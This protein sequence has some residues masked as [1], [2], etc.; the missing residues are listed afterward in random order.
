MRRKR[1]DTA[2][3]ALPAGLSKPALRALHGAGYTSLWQLTKAT[4]AQLLALHGLGPNGMAKIRAALDEAGL[5]FAK[6]RKS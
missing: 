1:A 2:T 3:D 5:T 6:A 4:E